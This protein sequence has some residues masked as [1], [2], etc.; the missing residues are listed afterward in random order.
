MVD[1]FDVL[2][3]HTKR[4]A[5]AAVLGSALLFTGCATDQ[6]RLQYAGD[7]AGRAK[8]TTA[9]ADLYLQEVDAAR[10]EANIDLIAADPACGRQ[11][12]VLRAVPTPPT[13][14][15]GTL[16]VP[17]SQ[18][19][20]LQ[21]AEISLAP[22][23]EELKPTLALISSLALYGEGLA[24]VLDGPGADPANTLADAVETARS[25]QGLLLALGAKAGRPLAADDARVSATTNLIR[26]VGT[27]AAEQRKVGGLRGYLALHGAETSQAILLLRRHLLTW[28]N[29]RKADQALR[30]GIV[31]VTAQ[32]VLARTPP[33][34]PGDRRAA[35]RNF[36]SRQRDAAAEAT[37]YLALDN[38]LQTLSSAD[39]DL[40]RV[41][42]EQPKLN[43]EERALVAEA[44]RKRVIR[45][46]DGI[47]AMIT[48]FPGA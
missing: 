36:Y 25:A 38:A 7:V 17:A 35:L 19:P 22:I 1:A 47:A 13:G 48:A 43:A 3:T 40:R 12:P 28:E 5:R 29:A 27:L 2:V 10:I 23:G 16:C 18:T 26:F 20:G 37:L 15:A 45:A 4:Q 32:A 8:A 33:A 46:M 31:A 30:S 6:L 9:A 39:G 42:V 44:T 21:D 11:R 24:E 14:A 41:I 34:S